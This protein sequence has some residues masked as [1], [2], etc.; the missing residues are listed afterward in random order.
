MD[1]KVSQSVGT[2]KD[3]AEGAEG[4]VEE[5]ARVVYNKA[6]DVKDGTYGAATAAGQKTGSAIR[7]VS[8]LS[9][10]SP[11]PFRHN[12]SD[13]IS[14]LW[15]EVENTPLAKTIYGFCVAT[16]PVKV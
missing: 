7:R 5:G 11:I 12:I 15:L 10:F 6:A 3:A 9:C 16:L 13:C 14:A 8:S 4:W 2:A 1:G